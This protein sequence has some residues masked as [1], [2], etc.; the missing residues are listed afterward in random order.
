MESLMEKGSPGFLHHRLGGKAP[1]LPLETQF[2]GW[3]FALLRLNTNELNSLS[4]EE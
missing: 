2:R 3:P 1:F 4:C